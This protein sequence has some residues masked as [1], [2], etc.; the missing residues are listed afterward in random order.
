MLWHL[1]QTPNVKKCQVV[2][3]FSHSADVHSDITSR[4]PNA[5]HQ[6][7][8]APE[9]LSTTVLPAVEIPALKALHTLEGMKQNVKPLLESTVCTMVLLGWMVP[10]KS[11][12]G[13]W[14]RVKCPVQTIMASKTWRSLWPSLLSV[15]TSHR[16]VAVES[17]LC[18]TLTTA[19]WDKH[20]VFICLH[21][22]QYGKYISTNM[23]QNQCVAPLSGTDHDLIKPEGLSPGS[24]CTAAVWSAE[25]RGADTAEPASGACDWGAPGEEGSHWRPSSLWSCWSPPTHRCWLSPVLVSPKT[26]M[27]ICKETLIDFRIKHVLAPE[28][29]NFL[30]ES[31]A[32]GDETQTNKQETRPGWNNSKIHYTTCGFKLM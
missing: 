9:T 23:L 13:R 14:G 32:Q 25:H 1:I 6:H 27:N 10:G 2:H 18:L 3:L 7:S 28:R 30:W 4:V 19:V 16:P 20:T 24:G 11:F 26:G 15:S 22:I 21:Y 5:D 31:S 17:G 12:S 8:F 29:S